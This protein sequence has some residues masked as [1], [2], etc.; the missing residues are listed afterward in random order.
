MHML[1][2]ESVHMPVQAN[3][4]VQTSLAIQPYLQC[5]GKGAGCLG[6]QCVVR[7]HSD[8]ALSK[9]DAIPS[10]FVCSLLPSM[11]V[12]V[13]IVSST[14]GELASAPV[15]CR[16]PRHVVWSQ[17]LRSLVWMLP[18]ERL[19]LAGTLSECTAALSWH[20]A[21]AD[22]SE[23]PTRHSGSQAACMLQI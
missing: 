20:S 3:T 18:R 10:H 6:S 8:L 23:D 16:L 12:Y 5:G 1:P 17:Q 21:F 19:L 11:C 9:A 13:D 14:L 4:A 2:T 22:D 7:P 15:G